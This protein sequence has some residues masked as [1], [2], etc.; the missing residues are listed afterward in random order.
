MKTQVDEKKEWP[1]KNAFIPTNM[2]FFKEFCIIYTDNIIFH[3]SVPFFK[4]RCRFMVFLFKIFKM[5]KIWKIIHKG[6]AAGFLNV[7]VKRIWTEGTTTYLRSL[8][9]WT[10]VRKPR[11]LGKNNFWNWILI[12]IQLCF[13]KSFSYYIH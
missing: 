1:F 4:K 5:K 13:Y 3:N 10:G 6:R 9:K 8:F 7:L 11:T 2:G 12:S